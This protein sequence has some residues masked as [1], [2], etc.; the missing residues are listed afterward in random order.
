[1]VIFPGPNI[2]ALPSG[3]HERCNPDTLCLPPLPEIVSWQWFFEGSAIP[4]ATS[5]QFVANQSGT[6]WAELMDINGCE[7]SSA[8]LTV[9]L[10]NGFGNIL[11]QV[12]S[13]VNDNGIIDAADTLVSGIPVQLLQNGTFIA[14]G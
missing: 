4:G 5:H 6:Y 2:S 9:E 7:A 13:D 11:G 14:P 1:M 12:W 3:C 8:P 10:Y